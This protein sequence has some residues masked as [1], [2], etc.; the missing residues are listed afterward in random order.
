MLNNAN[1]V[2]ALAVLSFK[3][4]LVRLLL[5]VEVLATATWARS[6]LNRIKTRFARLAGIKSERE[7][8]RS[9]RPFLAESMGPLGFEPRTKRL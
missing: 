5:L 3:S 8:S 2:A 1:S 4:S 7:A 9:S 6:D